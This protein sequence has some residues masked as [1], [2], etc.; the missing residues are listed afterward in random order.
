[1]AMSVAGLAVHMGFA[2]LAFHQ[3]YRTDLMLEAR[4]ALDVYHSEYLNAPLLGEP[5][6]P[7]PSLSLRPQRPASRIGLT[8]VQKQST[9]GQD[10][11]EETMQAN[12]SRMI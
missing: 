12:G 2:G 6:Q 5:E 9:D 11:A 1:M 3:R 7:M 8:V 10:N 4:D